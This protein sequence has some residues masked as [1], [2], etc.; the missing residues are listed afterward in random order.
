MKR[1]ILL[2][3][4]FLCLNVQAQD[5]P[6]IKADVTLGLNLNG[7]NNPLYGGN[8]RVNYL[9]QKGPWEFS[10]NPN[11]NINYVSANED[12]TLARREGYN[13]ISLSHVLNNKWKII[14]FS[15]TDHSFIRK[16]NLI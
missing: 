14:G 15:E 10:I 3:S 13:T 7:G 1:L 12:I 5:T 9:R 8:F 16:I 6:K 11:F 2:F 4:I